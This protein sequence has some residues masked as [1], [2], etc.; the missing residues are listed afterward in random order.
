[1]TP[2]RGEK[3]TTWEGGFRALCLV[4]WP[5]KIKPG[6][7][8]NEIFSGEDWLPTFLA[9]A[10]EEDVKEKLLAGHTANG[11]DFKVHL[12]GYNMLPL[13]TGDV[14]KGPRQE[15]FFFDDDGNLNAFRY[16]RWKMHFRI[17]EAIFYVE[18]KGFLEHNSITYLDKLEN[19]FGS[20]G[21]FSVWCWSSEY[22]SD[23]AE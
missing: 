5:A 7:I 9:A 22:K 6:Q 18:K 11:K 10:G 20:Q 14:A 3:A 8:S 17:Q 2:F 4:K 16:N 15:I 13:L 23:K 1:M 21:V 12:D 19:L